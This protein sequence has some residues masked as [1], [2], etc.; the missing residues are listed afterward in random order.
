[1]ATLYQCGRCNGIT[2]A[3]YPGP[4]GNICISCKRR[5]SISQA[6][7]IAPSD[8]ITVVKPDGSVVKIGVDAGNVIRE[9]PDEPYARVKRKIRVS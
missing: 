9:Q 1:M 5:G 7:T 3:A 4:E 2:G 8:Y 6:G